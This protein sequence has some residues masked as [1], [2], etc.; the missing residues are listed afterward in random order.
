[1]A[2]AIQEAV[3]VQLAAGLVGLVMA[4]MIADLPLGTARGSTETDIE[5]IGRGQ[6]WSQVAADH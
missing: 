1:M 6:A 5:H 3:L 2:G 4:W